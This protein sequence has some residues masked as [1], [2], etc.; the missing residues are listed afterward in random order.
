MISEHTKI[1]AQRA[2]AV[3][4]ERLQSKLEAEHLD[5]YVAIEPDSGDY[6]VAD[7]FSDAVAQSRAAHPDRISFVIWIGHEAAIHLGGMEH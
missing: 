5:K 6:F 2:K 3:Y 1:V 7:S 4:S